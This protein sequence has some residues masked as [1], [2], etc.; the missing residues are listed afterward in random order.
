MHLHSFERECTFVQTTSRR[1]SG[2]LWGIRTLASGTGLNLTLLRE[3]YPYGTQTWIGGVVIPF[4]LNSLL[5]QLGGITSSYLCGLCAALCFFAHYGEK[6]TANPRL[7]CK[8]NA[9]PTRQNSLQSELNFYLIT[10]DINS[11]KSWVNIKRH[12]TTPSRKI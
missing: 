3:P 1:L 10:Q 2:R 8:F 9:R 7:I 5:T 4:Q 11:A 12:L 6:R